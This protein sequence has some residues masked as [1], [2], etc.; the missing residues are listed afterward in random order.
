MNYVA[1]LCFT[2]DVFNKWCK[3][4]EIKEREK[5]YKIKYVCI[6]NMHNAEGMSYV[7]IVRLAGW[8]KMERAD[9][10][11]EYVESHILK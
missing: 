9:E 2:R 11:E 5:R 6:Q 10:V 7:N 3:D 8:W 4:L 1:V